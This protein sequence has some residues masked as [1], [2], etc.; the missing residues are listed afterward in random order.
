MKIWSLLPSATEML[1]AVGAGEQVTGVTH[2]CD[3]PGDATSRPRV[4]FSNIDSSQPSSEIDRRV[5]EHFQSGRRLY[6]IDED[7][8]RTDPP[9]LVI[10]QDLCP[11][12]AVS[13]SDFAGHLTSAG[14]AAEMLTLNPNTLEDVFDDITRVGEAT[15]RA[16]E[17]HVYVDSLRQRIMEIEQAVAGE[18]RRRVLCVEWLDPPMPGGHWVPEMVRIAGGVGGPIEP[19]QPSRKMAWEA[20]LADDPEVIVLMPCGFEPVR[21]AL[22]AAPLWREAWWRKLPA[23]RTGNVFCTNGN[24]YFSRPGPRLVDG[25]HILARILHRGAELTAAPPGSIR[26]LRTVE[27]GGPQVEEHS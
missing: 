25:I 11:V 8:L 14:C 18:P 20:M 21:A 26:K 12:C 19:G 16:A 17:A 23:V 3:F 10:T 13:P 9:D 22:E 5:T 27:G 4:T 1:F 2:E 15:G 6:G 7:R 24:A